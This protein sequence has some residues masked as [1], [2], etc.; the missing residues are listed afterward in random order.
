MLR[1]NIRGKS[2]Q[3]PIQSNILYMSFF[4]FLTAGLRV[5]GK[6][7][8]PPRAS[9]SGRDVRPPH[10][11]LFKTNNMNIN[12]PFL[13]RCFGFKT[14]SCQVSPHSLSSIACSEGRGTGSLRN[15]RD[16]LIF[17][18]PQLRHHNWVLL[19]SPG[20]LFPTGEP[21]YAARSTNIIVYLVK[22]T[23]QAAIPRPRQG[24]TLLCNA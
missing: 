20:I 22:I 2:Y 9:K 13:E 18:E 17:D 14:L 1:L 24:K 6:P 15:L 8:S 7:K 12:N 23:S 19:A 16:W 5:T 21:C 11:Q 3:V 10:T 4:F